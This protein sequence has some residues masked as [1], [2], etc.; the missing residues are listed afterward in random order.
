MYILNHK[1]VTKDFPE[2]QNITLGDVVNIDIQFCK[3]VVGYISFI[4]VCDYII[5]M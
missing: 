1:F 5:Y 3:K 2:F 4:N